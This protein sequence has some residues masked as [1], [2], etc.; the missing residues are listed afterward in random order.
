MAYTQAAKAIEDP[1]ATPDQLVNCLIALR[2]DFGYING[3]IR[4][5]RRINAD[6]DLLRIIILS[7]ILRRRIVSKMSLL[8]ES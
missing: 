8:S 3:C 4:C 7:D 6:S 2:D 5:G 1:N